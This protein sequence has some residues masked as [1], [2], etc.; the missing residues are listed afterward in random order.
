MSRYYHLRLTTLLTPVLL[1]AACAQEKSANP[2]SPSVAGPIAGVAISAPKLL[3]PASGAQV[4]F[5]QQ[6]ITLMVGNST[7]TGVRTLSY[8]FEIASDSAFSSKIFSQTGVAAG[9]NGQTSFRLPQPLSADRTYFWRA[10]A[11]DGANTGDYAAPMSFKVF[12]PVVINPPSPT[13][14]ADGA[15]LATLQPKF[16]V[17]NSTHTGP[18]TQIS[19]VLEVATDGAFGSK[20]L[21]VEYPESSNT[22]SMTPSAPLPANTRLYWHV[23]ATDPGHESPWSPTLSF[24]TPAPAAAPPPAPVP[25][26]SSGGQLGP[27]DQLDLH[28]VTIVLGAAGIADWPVTSTVTSTTTQDHNFC[29]NHTMLGQWP[30]TPFFGDPSTPLE[31]NQ[32]VFANIGGKWYGGAADWYRPGQ[33]CKDVTQSNI[34]SDGFYN[35]EPLRSWSPKPGETFGVMDSTPARLYPDMRTIDQRTNVVLVKWG[36]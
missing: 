24:V 6:P 7:S 28:S 35:W 4:S 23:K 9:S 22:T 3:Q 20:V 32:W 5:E 2:T 21:A 13:A 30:T 8:V 11:E 1:L 16:T 17:T 26:P 36:Q 12:T 29:I 33:G 19:Y 31:G 18:I 34:G 14:P 25:P 27:G 10:R 15:T